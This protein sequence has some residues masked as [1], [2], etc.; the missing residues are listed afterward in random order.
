MKKLLRPFFFV[1][2]L[3][4]CTQVATSSA[5][6]QTPDYGKYGTTRLDVNEVQV[7]NDYVPPY[8]APNVEHQ[9]YLP[10]YSAIRDWGM[11]RFKAVGNMGLAKIH[12]LDASVVKADRPIKKG[13]EGWFY[14]QV[15]AEYKLSVLVRLEIVSPSYENIPYA[16]VKASRKL[17]VTEGMTLNQRDAALN[18]MVLD[19][20]DDLDRLMTESIQNNL[21]NVVR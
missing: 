2:M 16:E 15:E 1:M 11:N 17:E 9:L 3:T 5:P 14:D 10:P 4:A 13:A 20:L 21:S 19:M 6:L 7:V 18:K 12:I 8:A